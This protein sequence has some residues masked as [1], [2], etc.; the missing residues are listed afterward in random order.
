MK[1]NWRTVQIFL[2]PTTFKI[3]EV[4]LGKESSN[5]IRCNCNI[6]SSNKSCKHTRFVQNHMKKNGGHYSVQIPQEIPDE[7]VTA[8]MESAESFRNFIIN[9]AKIEVIY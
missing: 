3:Y 8:A 7:E 1:E 5:N 2:E 6:F 9:Y 4:E